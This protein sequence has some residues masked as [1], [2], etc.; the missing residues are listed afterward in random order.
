MVP[1]IAPALGIP[2]SLVPS[3]LFLRRFPKAILRFRRLLSSANALRRGSIR[4]LYE[5]ATAWSL[6]FVLD[7]VV[8]QGWMRKILDQ[9][10]I[11]ED[12]WTIFCSYA[13]GSFWVSFGLEKGM[14]LWGLGRDLALGREMAG[15]RLASGVHLAM[16]RGQEVLGVLVGGASLTVLPTASTVI[17]ALGGSAAAAGTFIGLIRRYA[18]RIATR[19]GHQPDVWG[20]W[21]E[22]DARDLVGW[23]QEVERRRQAELRRERQE[24]EA[25]AQWED[26]ID[27][28][29]V[30][31]EMRDLG[32]EWE[33]VEV[34]VD[35]MERE[36]EELGGERAEILGLKGRII[37]ALSSPVEGSRQWDIVGDEEKEEAK[38]AVE[39]ELRDAMREWDWE[40]VEKS[41]GGEAEVWAHE[42]AAAAAEAKKKSVLPAAGAEVDAWAGAEVEE[43]EEDVE[44]DGFVWVDEDVG[45]GVLE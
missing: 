40:M 28:E 32:E 11:A 34:D 10:G 27:A 5:Y 1:V 42:A 31:A 22:L 4:A 6:R 24:A 18:R 7:W 30:R 35:G 15:Q 38:K 3:L 29:A 44:V 25:D 23:E 13:V 9:W 14:E 20:E 17:A 2:V 26:D 43:E 8:G 41:P 12:A 37:E 16:D 36:I 19:R 39:K 21:I 45:K 33:V